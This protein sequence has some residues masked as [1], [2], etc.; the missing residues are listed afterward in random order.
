LA[1]VPI[2][3]VTVVFQARQRLSEA[4]DAGASIALTAAFFVFAVTAGADWMWEETA[5][6][7]LA[8]GGLAIAGAGGSERLCRHRRWGPT[9]RVGVRVSIVLIAIAAAAFE[10][11]GIVATDRTRASESAVKDGDLR[12]ARELADAAV[13]AQP[14]AASPRLQLGIALGRQGRLLAARRSVWSAQ[15]KEPTNWRIPL[16]LASVEAQLGH[17]AAATRSFRQAR[18]LWPRSPF[19]RAPRP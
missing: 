8:L 18:E 3:L 16:V 9:P 17:R 7:G 11:P 12:G 5:V 15:A 19:F 4:G 14:W 6:S 13:S 2:G 1:A 10:V